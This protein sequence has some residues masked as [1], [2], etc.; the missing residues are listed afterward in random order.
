MISFPFDLN[1]TSSLAATSANAVIT[2]SL[3]LINFP[4]FGIFT[5]PWIK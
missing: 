4:S 1:L 2:L 5:P 3:S